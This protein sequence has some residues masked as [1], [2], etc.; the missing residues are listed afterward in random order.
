MRRASDGIIKKTSKRQSR[1]IPPGDSFLWWASG[2][3]SFGML[4]ECLVFIPVPICI[5][6]GYDSSPA[7][8]RLPG[9]S[10]GYAGS[11]VQ[12]ANVGG[13]PEHRGSAHVLGQVVPPLH[14]GGHADHR[15][16]VYLFCA[17]RIQAGPDPRPDV[18]KFDR[19]E[20]EKVDLNDL[21]S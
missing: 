21:P 6:M 19:Q 17:Q 4:R 10:S 8:R 20:E 11:F 5:A 9:R 13:F 18:R 1:Q 3:G 12:A 7:W 16:G 15:G 2:A 14:P